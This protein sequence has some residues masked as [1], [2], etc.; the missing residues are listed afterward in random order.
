MEK[1]LFSPISTQ[2]NFNFHE[3][4][5]IEILNSS[6]KNLHSMLLVLFLNLSIL[7]LCFSL[8]IRVCIANYDINLTNTYC[9]SVFT[10][11]GMLIPLSLSRKSSVDKIKSLIIISYIRKA[12]GL[13]SGRC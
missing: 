10:E 8:N 7:S 13:G 12:K 5:C 4:L 1:L 6:H 9:Y 2:N 3:R 11:L